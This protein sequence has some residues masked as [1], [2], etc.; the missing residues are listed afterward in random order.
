M[1]TTVVPEGFGSN[2]FI[3][4]KVYFSRLMR[5]CLGFSNVSGV[6]LTQVSFF[7]LVSSVWKISLGI[8]P[9]FPLAG[10]LCKFT[11]T[12]EENKKYSARYS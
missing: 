3:T 4:H 5:V 11:P 7:L 8:G 9:C 10:G 6:Y 2:D 12:L 1:S